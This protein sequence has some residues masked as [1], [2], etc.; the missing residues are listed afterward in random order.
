[1]GGEEAQ[2]PVAAPAGQPLQQ[3]AQTDPGYVTLEAHP[4]KLI[5]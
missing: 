5:Y 2:D 1:V 3:L 4:W